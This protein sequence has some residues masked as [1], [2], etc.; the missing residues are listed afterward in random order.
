MRVFHCLGGECEATCCQHWDIRYD[1]LHYEI[2]RDFVKKDAVQHNLFQQ[3]VV[4]SDVETRLGAE[5]CSH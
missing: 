4:V 1:R 3:Y 2:F 5:L